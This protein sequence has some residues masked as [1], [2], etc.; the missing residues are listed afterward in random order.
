[1]AV[2]SINQERITMRYSHPWRSRFPVA[3]LI[4]VLLLLVAC[5]DSSGV[6]RGGTSAISTLENRAW[7]TEAEFA[8]DPD[9]HAT[10]GQAIVLD[11]ESGDSAA[12]ENRH[13]FVVDVWEQASFCLAGD[14]PLLHH[15]EV[16]QTGTTTVEGTVPLAE[17]RL[18][19]S[20]S[21]GAPCSAIDLEPGTY[22]VSAY[23][24]AGS[25]EGSLSKAFLHQTNRAQTFGAIAPGDSAETFGRP[26][27]MAFTAPD[28]GIVSDNITTLTPVPLMTEAEVVTPTEVFLLKWQTNRRGKWE[29]L[30]LD[31]LARPILF[32][33]A[34]D[35][36]PPDN[37]FYISPDH[38]GLYC[39]DKIAI[40]MPHDHGDGVFDMFE[41]SSGPV[42]VNASNELYHE[43][44]NSQTPG[45]T[46]TLLYKVFDCAGATCDATHLPLQQGEVAFFQGCG[47]EGP[48]TVFMR[49]TS[50]LGIFE[51]AAQVNVG[52]SPGTALSVR[53]GPDTLASIYPEKDYGGA[54]IEVGAD[55]ACLADVGIDTVAS[56]R[57]LDRDNYILSSKGCT[58][59][60]LNGI[61]LGGEDLGNYDFSGA[62][63]ENAAL[64]GTILRGANLAN[65]S[66]SRAA[67]DSATDF[68]DADLSCTDLDYVD[69]S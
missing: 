49:D 12:V 6:A 20:H 13:R 52:V 68:T 1:M 42:A 4:L 14:E 44:G 33:F 9:L 37:R 62:L 51:E 55:T 24:D 64:N 21:A 29:F 26:D 28:G 69:L 5:S 30:F 32:L 66:L 31:S 11:L 3:P 40:I 36:C 39:E 43:V 41:T 61:D 38:G 57:I 19:H 35:E 7:V 16:W 23:H 53:V 18:L 59:C 2:S 60:V 22:T 34:Q 17:P 8:G 67:L 25:V 50:N 46:M 47:F 45:D 27:F 56:L 54:A 63:L 15:L 48:A 65:A 58:G 10:L